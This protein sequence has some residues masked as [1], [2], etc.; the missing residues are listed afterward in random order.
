MRAVK[1]NL[2]FVIVGIATALTIGS[3]GTSVCKNDKNRV[4]GRFIG[5]EKEIRSK[6]R[7]QSNR[8]HG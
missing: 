8:V 6:P 3:A 2:V 5:R 1:D 7:S 4:R